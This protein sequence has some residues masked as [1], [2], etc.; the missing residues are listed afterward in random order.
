MKQELQQKYYNHNTSDLPEIKNNTNAYAQLK[1]N[2][3]WNQHWYSR[4]SKFIKPINNKEEYCHSSPK[5]EEKRHVRN[6]EERTEGQDYETEDRK[7]GNDCDSSESEDTENVPVHSSDNVEGSSN[8][9]SNCDT[10]D[11]V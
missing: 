8:D 2:S 6:E 5:R 9:N 7:H 10:T 1:L 3:N 4:N 11:E